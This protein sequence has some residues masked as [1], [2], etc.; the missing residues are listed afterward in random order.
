MTSG[1]TINWV[2][3]ASAKDRILLSIIIIYNYPSLSWEASDHLVHI[4]GAWTSCFD[5]TIDTCALT[6]TGS[7]L[8]LLLEFSRPI[9]FVHIHLY[10]WLTIFCILNF[11][12]KCMHLKKRV[13]IVW[14]AY[15]GIRTSVDEAVLAPPLFTQIYFQFWHLNQLSLLTMI[16]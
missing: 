14:Q 15:M 10:L 2:S 8:G 1:T 16:E 7:S 12:S 13:E 3:T 11:S 6:T 5:Q 4:L 9:L